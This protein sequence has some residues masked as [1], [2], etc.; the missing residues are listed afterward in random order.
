MASRNHNHGKKRT[1]AVTGVL[2]AGVLF[3]FALPAAVQAQDLENTLNNLSRAAGKAYVAP[4]V[5][6]FGA[7]MNA[8]WFHKAPSARLLGIDFEFGVVAMGT[9]VKDD[10]KTFETSGP[11]QFNYDQALELASQVTAN[12]VLQGLIAEQIAA[13]T[14]TVGIS[15][16][17]AVGSDMESIMIGFAGDRISV[18]GTEYDIPVQDIDLGIG[19]VLSDLSILPH[20]A[21]Q[22][23]VGTVM[24]TQA[25]L[26]YL[27]ALEISSEIGELE[28]L[29]FGIQHNPLVWLPGHILIPVNVSVGYFTQKLTVGDLFECTTSAFGVN[30]SRKFGAGLGITPYAGF[31]LE[32]S[33]MTFTYDYLVEAA[34]GVVNENSIEF[35]MKGENKSRLIVGAALNLGLINIVADYNIAKH[36]NISAGVF[37][38]F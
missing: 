5:N 25:T 20:A 35:T 38:G 17:T 34:P 22:L 28:Y 11:F 27:P 16:P 7:N 10:D 21:P 8:G 2:C 32:K 15:G 18:G 29:G 19:G 4:L 26:R 13:Q 3:S 12:Q 30:V 9:L 14:Y 23:S 33:E 24:G 36:Q 31:M 37:I 6:G 1:A